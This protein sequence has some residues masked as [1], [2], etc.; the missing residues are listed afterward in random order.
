MEQLLSATIKTTTA[1]A[2]A[3]TTGAGA[4]GAGAGASGSVSVQQLL[5]AAVSATLLSAADAV[6]AAQAQTQSL[7]TRLLSGSRDLVV[8]QLPA[9]LQRLWTWQPTFMQGFLLG[10]VTMLVLLAMAIKY[11]LFEEP[12]GRRAADADDDDDPTAAAAAAVSPAG[13]RAAGGGARTVVR[14][15]GFGLSKFMIFSRKAKEPAADGSQE[16]LARLRREIL[17]RTGYDLAGGRAESCDWLTVFV[18]QIVGKFRADAERHDRLVRVISEAL[19]GELRPSVLDSLRITQFSLGSDFLRI[20]AARM[21]PSAGPLG[22]RAEV[23][24][25]L[26]DEV[27]LG[28][29]TRVLVNW[30]RP[31]VAALPVSIVVSLV[32]FVATVAVEF[33][34]A[35]ADPAL[36]VSVLPDYVLEFDVQTLVGSKAKVQNLPMLTSV[37]GRKLQAAF[38]KELVMPSEKRVR[39]KH[40]FTPKPAASPPAA[41]NVPASPPPPQPPSQPPLQPVSPVAEA[42]RPAS[43]LPPRLAELP[44]DYN[45]QLP[46]PHPLRSTQHSRA[47]VGGNSASPQMGMPPRMYTPEEPVLLQPQSQSLQPQPQPRPMSQRAWSPELSAYGAGSPQIR[48]V[49]GLSSATLLGPMTYGPGQ[50]IGAGQFVGA[51]RRLSSNLGA[52][53]A[54]GSGMLV[55][56]AATATTTAAGA[57]GA[58][59]MRPGSSARH[60]T[61]ADADADDMQVKDSVRQRVSRVIRTVNES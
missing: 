12:L 51:G 19:N 43:P 18:A 2:A 25:A 48:P 20:G 38:A 24:V 41:S 39:I 6:S 54:G 15:G 40:P 61:T 10:Q 3:A 44:P 36:V 31:A 52:V 60:A 50:F 22:M 30:P 29:D 33:D 37:I 7:H 55:G 13:R 17:A 21:A 59:A 34:C 14:E 11:I 9:L 58:H 23:D 8:L 47:A 5:T 45:T 4:V 57:A 26:H 16:E 28:F 56:S 35:A 53:P 1:A 46:P 49:I 42:H 27:T 32:K